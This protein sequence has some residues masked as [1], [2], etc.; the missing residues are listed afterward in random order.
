MKI[1]VDS[2]VI[3]A[4]LIRDSKNREII[5]NNKFDF[6]TPDFV[7][8]EIWKYKDYLTDK[9]NISDKDFELLLNLILKNIKII[10][11]EKYK[12]SLSKAKEIMK[13][14]LKDS[15]YVACYLELKCNGI[16][17]HDPDFECKE[18]IKLF[19]TKDLLDLLEK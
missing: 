14:D 1:I 4:A 19:K 17:T 10:P 13:N 18:G 7:V 3:I 8:A 9:I 16:W 15:P 12:N 5:K 6:I 11:V 2:N